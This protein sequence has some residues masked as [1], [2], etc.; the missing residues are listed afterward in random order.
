M[1]KNVED[2]EEI[3]QLIAR[4]CHHVDKYEAAEFAALFSE[5]GVLDSGGNKTQGTEA[6]RNFVERMRS[7]PQVSPMRHI[8]TNVVID[9]VGDEATS[10]SYIVLLLPGSPTR[11]GLTASYDDRLR[12]VD[13]QWRFVERRIIPDV[14]AA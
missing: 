14:S 11:I 3:R 2:H 7:S 6:L 13:G 12:R 5:D 4:Y 1:L 10:Q 8:V 9:V